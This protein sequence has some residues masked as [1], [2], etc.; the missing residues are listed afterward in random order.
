MKRRSYPEAQSLHE[1]LSDEFHRR[2]G[3]RD[4]NCEIAEADA[5]SQRAAE[6]EQR[7]WELAGTAIDEVKDRS[8]SAPHQA[9]RRQRLLEGPGEFR[10]ARVD[11]IR[12]RTK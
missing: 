1:R 5:P 9:D 4:R 11:R 7:A 6:R 12:R 10:S 2:S 3:G 8:A